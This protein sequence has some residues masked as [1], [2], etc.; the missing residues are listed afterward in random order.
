MMFKLLVLCFA[1]SV[2][3]T[4]AIPTPD[5]A[6]KPIQF[7]KE[8]ATH[9]ET[10]PE[11]EPETE[12]E[13]EPQ[14]DDGYGLYSLSKKKRGAMDDMQKAK[15]AVL[16]KIKVE[17]DICVHH[18]QKAKQN[19]LALVNDGT[20][21]DDAMQA[22]LAIVATP[23]D[24]KE[25]DTQ[26]SA[27]KHSIQLWD[28]IEAKRQSL[29][30]VKQMKH[31]ALEAYYKIRTE[32][33]TNIRRAMLYSTGLIMHVAKGGVTD[34]DNT[35]DDM[36]TLISF[37]ADSEADIAVAQL[38]QVSASPAPDSDWSVRK[39]RRDALAGMKDLKNT[40]LNAIKAAKNRA[41]MTIKT[42]FSDA[43]RE[44]KAALNAKEA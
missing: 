36:I 5:A 35:I 28:L 16:N 22:A 9:L 15:E 18:I 34:A 10:E 25:L 20:A 26:L 8:Q 33:V 24:D 6:A 39:A 17:K 42:D 3:L 41:L 7:E 44:V 12:P 32:S 43:V 19:A 4:M 38:L 40:H 37:D 1:L 21:M 14:G 23:S 29:Q 31:D 2:Q 27:S 30:L 11:Y 13:P